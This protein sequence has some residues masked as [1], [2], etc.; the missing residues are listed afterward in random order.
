MSVNHSAKAFGYRVVSGFGGCIAHS[1][2]VKYSLGENYK[3]VNL[4]FTMIS[5]KTTYMEQ[6]EVKNILQIYGNLL[7]GLINHLKSFESS[8]DK[9]E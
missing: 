6:T 5:K 1:K 8:L 2:S 3:N 7:N 4:R 9:L